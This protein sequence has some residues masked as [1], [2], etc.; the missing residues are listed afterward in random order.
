MIERYSLPE[1]KNLWAVESKYNFWLK[2]ELAVC[3]AF[4]EIGDISDDEIAAILEKASF[5]SERIDEIEEEVKHD[6]LSFL[7]SVNESLGDL[8][9]YMHV[10]L[11]SSDVIDTALSLQIREANLILF[12]DFTKLLGL[13]RAKAVEYKDVVM[14]GRSHGIHAEPTTLGLKFALWYDVMKRN[15]VRLSQS[16]KEIYVG[17]I[18]GAVGTYANIDPRIEEA[19][20]RLLDLQQAK[21]CTQVIQ[22]DIHARYMQTLG[23]IATSIESIA[24]EIR[25]LQRTD[26]LELEEGFSANQKGSSAMPHK[27]NPISSENLCGLAR[28]VRANASSALDNIPLWH[29][30]DMSH[31]SV[32]RIILPDSTILLNYML[33]RLVNTLER[34]TIYP[35]NM[36]RNMNK[37]GGIIFSQQVMLKLVSKGMKRERAYRIVQKNAHKAWNNPEGD[38]KKNLLSDKKVMETLS[39]EELDSCFDPAY[40]LRNIDYIYHKLEL[41]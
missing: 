25:S 1:M 16:A 24:L 41:L 26:V 18:S 23:L 31:S 39:K 17:K 36:L 6:F 11:T 28:V 4:N 35:E 9:R 30:R 37:F 33:N 34:L 8:A 38:F 15:Y 3:Q 2:V 10:G 7:T 20:C 12:Y 14:I 27:R 29:E 13:L 22:R 40:H 19:T 32:E 5:N 21:T